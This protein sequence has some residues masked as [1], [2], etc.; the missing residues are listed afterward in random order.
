MKFTTVLVTQP[1]RIRYLEESLKQLSLA[2]TLNHNMNLLVIFNGESHQGES[3]LTPIINMH[4]ERVR[5]K[6]IKENSPLPTRLVSIIRNEGLRWVHLPGDD[7][8]VIP[9]SY[10]N[11]A[12]AL[13]SHPD[14]IAIA[15]SA[16][17]IDANGAGGEK[18]LRPFNVNRASKSETLA[19]ALHKPLFIWPSLMFDFDALPK[20]IFVSR[21]VFD[22]WVGLSLFLAGDIQV[23]QVPLIHYR[24]HSDQESFHTSENRKRFEAE[25]M[26]GATLLQERAQLVLRN[27]AD[28]KRFLA[29]IRRRPPIYGDPLFGASILLMLQNSLAQEISELQSLP[30][31][32][33]GSFTERHGILMNLQEFPAFSSR[34]ASAPRKFNFRLDVAEETCRPM[35][36]V[37]DEI[38]ASSG[39]IVGRIGCIHTSSESHHSHLAIQ[40]DCTGIQNQGGDSTY[41]KA[42]CRQIESQLDSLTIA[43]EQVAYW[44]IVVIRNLRK[45]L[46]LMRKIRT[47]LPIRWLRF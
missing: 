25:M 7:D 15:F 38:L 46:Y 18:V 19:N 35:R 6:T 37:L 33:L 1:S 45:L 36:K 27:Q 4:G 23:V 41:V 3:I 24:I 20:N 32:Y 9:E 10:A 30:E 8:L 44:E 47:R 17:T 39:A 13:D 2:L 5:S 42:V 34:E 31:G 16:K 40:V 26:L 22:W 12:E 28:H 11:F 14:S 29:E 21:F 43:D